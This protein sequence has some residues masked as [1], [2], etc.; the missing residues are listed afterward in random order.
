MKT[1]RTSL[2]HALC[3]AGAMMTVAAATSSAAAQHRWVAT[4]D[5]YWHYFFNWDQFTVPTSSDDVDFLFHPLPRRVLFGTPTAAA[6][7]IDVY[8][9]VVDLDL[10]GT[11]LTH[12]DVWVIGSFLPTTL[13]LIGGRINTQG[14]AVLGSFGYPQHITVN[15]SVW[16]VGQLSFYSNGGV[17][18]TVTVNS[19][20]LVEI[21]DLRSSGPPPS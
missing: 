1:R 2:T 4:T 8:D 11:T 3:V 17:E 6:A 12:R 5:S 18:S 16:D 20:S 10:L 19:G 7:R 21:G 14:F 13:N 15:G 9:S